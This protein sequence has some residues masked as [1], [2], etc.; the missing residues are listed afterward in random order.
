MSLFPF[1]T[2]LFLL[3]YLN[4]KLKGSSVYPKWKD[5]FLIVQFIIVALL[6]V[7]A[8]TSSR[9]W[10]NWIW[11]FLL[12]VSIGAVLKVHE[13][14]KARPV[15]VAVLPMFF[16][17][18]IEDSVKLLNRDFYERWDDY[19]SAATFFAVVWLLAFVFIIRKQQ[20]AQEQELL[21][22]LA[23]DAQNRII[24][25]RKAA[26]EIEVQERTGELLAQKEELEKIVLQLQATQTQLVQQEK[27]ASLGELTAGIA[28]EIQNP[29]NFVNNFAE[30]SAEL[31]E[32][33]KEGPLQN[34]SESDKEYADE[35]LQDLKQNLSKIVFHGKRADGI[36][37]GMLMH[38][39]TN[40]GKKEPT[41]INALADEYLRLSYHGL[42]AKDKSFNSAMHTDLDPSLGM[43]EAV[44]QD[45]GRV[46]LNI[47]NNAFYSVSEKKKIQPET[48]GPAVWVSSRKIVSDNGTEMLELVI[49]DN[50]MG[51]PETVLEKL[52][53]PFFTTKPAG[54]G[55]GL[56]LS[57]SYDI[58]TKGHNG[59]MKVDSKEGEFAEFTIL[60]PLA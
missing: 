25:E 44:P 11:N 18:L 4:K 54:Q 39:R 27:L 17:A 23:E 40:T 13:F 46:L 20:K 59:E 9:P 58:I 48:Y 1:L 28:H 37:K 41:D 50:G 38:S 31:L 8:V 53:Q 16:V 21:R 35:I 14:R 7:E 49:R 24:A 5:I 10:F 6:V 19:F 60:L 43:V 26:L 29:L 36:V 57:I 12:F 56:G 47:F 15:I 30:V 32:E 22:R 52:Y 55:T 45:I 51:I 34:I 2:I 3:Q 42:R 33:L